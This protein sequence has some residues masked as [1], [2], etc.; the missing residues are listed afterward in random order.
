MGGGRT[1]VPAGS[2]T[3]NSP[4]TFVA[5]DITTVSLVGYGLVGNP[6]NPGNAGNPGP[7]IG[8]VTT[9]PPAFPISPPGPLPNTYNPATWGS[10]F[11]GRGL[12]GGG[13][14]SGTS[15]TYT[16]PIPSWY[17]ASST[18]GGSGGHL[19]GFPTYKAA[20]MNNG[21]G[22]FY[23]DTSGG[24]NIFGAPGFP[25]TQG[26]PGNPGNPGNTGSS[27]SALGRT[28]PGGTGGNPG[29]GGAG[30]SGGEGGP[31]GNAG[32]QMRPNFTPD[33]NFFLGAPNT[34][35]GSSSFGN[36]GSGQGYNFAQQSPPF[37]RGGGGA[38]TV[39]AGQPGAQAGSGGNSY[40]APTGAS[41]NASPNT[42]GGWIAGGGG[43]PGQVVSEHG[44]LYMQGSSLSAGAGAG[45]DRGEPGNPAN[46]GNA[47]NA[48]GPVT[49]TVYN[50]VPVT[51]GG[52]YPVSVGSGGRVVI[53][54][55]E[56]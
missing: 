13:G 28:F 9:N 7:G 18:S 8:Y 35:G 33:G 46:P 27:S 15:A 32:G 49:P 31:K 21:G 48:G 23:P 24:R 36:G 20:G 10:P 37:V 52:S 25:R 22:S 53:S 11:Q 45:G 44:N 34:S 42:E 50:S 3:F 17:T 55:N 30:G 51:P 54:W 2:Q 6:G 39:N 1:P 40:G 14:G 38:G 43:G 47:G 12:G 5:A 56:Q 26:T 4:G 41:V 16:G 29:S 19:P